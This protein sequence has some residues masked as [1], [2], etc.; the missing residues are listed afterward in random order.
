MQQANCGLLLSMNSTEISA[1]DSITLRLI[2]DNL[3]DVEVSDPSCP[4]NTFLELYDNMNK[5]VISLMIYK[6]DPSCKEN[7]FEIKSNQAL[8]FHYPYSLYKLFQVKEGF[9]YLLKVRFEGV[10]IRD[11]KKFICKNIDLK[12]VI[13]IK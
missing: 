2:N 3:F 11:N 5:R 8:Q 7:F 10:V 4:S 13:K 1:T 12:T 9:S 6:A